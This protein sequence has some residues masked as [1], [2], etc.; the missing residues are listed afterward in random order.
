MT[1][2]I[3]AILFKE[4]R[5]LWRDPLSLG[6]AIV[7]PLVLLVLFGYGLNLDVPPV[8]LGVLDLDRSAASR[9]FLSSKIPS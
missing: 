5:E 1:R 4:L 8:R 7:L 6:L 2:A 3:R 9:D